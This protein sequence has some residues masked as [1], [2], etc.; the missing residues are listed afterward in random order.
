MERSHATCDERPREKLLFAFFPTFR[1]RA[2]SVI[3]GLNHETG[4]DRSRPLYWKPSTDE[5]TVT[6]EI[7]T[8]TPA[9]QGEASLILLP[10]NSPQK[11]LSHPTRIGFPKT[12]FLSSLTRT[13]NRS[14]PQ[15]SLNGAHEVLAIA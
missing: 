14:L 5:T 2:H 4:V 9:S 13:E 15:L 8:S 1:S 11:A 3:M 10:W 12:S 6:P 7:L